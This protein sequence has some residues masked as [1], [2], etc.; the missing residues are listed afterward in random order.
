MNIPVIIDI[1]ELKNELS[2]LDVDIGT[3]FEAKI[4]TSAN[5]P[6]AAAFYPFPIALGDF[7]AYD[8]GQ[9][10]KAKNADNILK[11]LP[12]IKIN[13]YFITTPLLEAASNIYNW[14]DSGK[15]DGIA[16]AESAEGL[17]DKFKE[18]FTGLTSGNNWKKIPETLLDGINDTISSKD[19]VIL[20][21]LPEVL[22]YR[23]YTTTHNNTYILPCLLESDYYSS[24]GSYGW[25]SSG[26]TSND[27]FGIV[28]RIE[29]SPFE[30]FTRAL[31]TNLMPMFNTSNGGAKGGNVTITF[32]L[33]NETY[34]RAVANTRLIRSLVLCNK[35][36][37][38]GLSQLPGN[39]YDVSLLGT[40]QRWFMCTADIKVKHLGALRRLRSNQSLPGAPKKEKDKCRIPDG[41]SVT[42]TFESLLPDNL[43]QLLLAKDAN[44]KLFMNK[45]S[46]YTTLIENA[47]KVFNNI[48]TGNS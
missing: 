8:N 33:L 20:K 35:W 25:A 2:N 28:K 10:N 14:F 45:P 48:T 4:I 43:N 29:N 9:P 21:G 32:T 39:L 36:I 23:L 1:A 38:A 30:L 34:S 12:K 18:F 37:Q 41:Y 26:M 17:T 15:K 42:I 7:I 47:G 40:G 6:S 16:A 44:N 24:V 11:A 5:S 3:T 31:G 19:D 22:Y 13:S 46:V 27:P